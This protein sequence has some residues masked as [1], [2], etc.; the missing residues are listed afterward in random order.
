[1]AGNSLRS[2]GWLGIGI[3]VVLLT[4]FLNPLSALADTNLVVGGQ[5]RISY[6]NGDDVRMRT[7]P[8]YDGTLIKFVPEGTILDVV[9]GPV[10]DNAGNIWY[11]LALDGDTGYIVSDYL[12][13]TDSA[14]P[15]SNNAAGAVVG[16]ALIAG[17][18][19]DGV[20]CRTS[21]S[22]GGAVIT[23]VPEGSIVDLTGAAA[24]GWQPINC[25]GQGG[26]VSTDYVS[27][28]FSNGASFGADSAT[29]SASISGT[30]GD[31][32]RCRASATASAAIITVLSEGSVVS[33]RG[34]AEAGWQPVICAGS[35]G[36]VS[37]DF[38]AYDGGVGADS[39]ATA[40]SAQSTGT[41]TVS[42][43]NGDG[44]RCRTR[45]SLDGSIITVLGEGT[46]VNGRGSQKGDWM[47][48]ACAG[49]N[50]W[51]SA[52]YLSNGG[53][54][55]DGG[56]A[57]SG[58]AT[59]TGTGGGLRCRDDAS[60]NANVLTVLS[61]G[62]SVALR[63]SASGSWQPVVCE[64]MNGYVFSDYLSY[65]G[66][67]T[68]GGGNSGNNN[69]G[70]S[71]GD[72]ATVS[73]TN[74]D[75]VRFRSSASFDGAVIMV[76]GE[77]TAVSVI[78]G[79]TGSWVAIS[80]KGT[81]GFVHSDYL[82]AGGG[83]STDGGTDS[84]SAFDVGDHAKT[85]SDLNLRYDPS[86]SGGIAAVA[87]SGTVVEITGGVSNGYYAVDWD[88]LS[89]YMHG[90][91]L[92][93]TKDGL[94]ERGGS[95]EDGGGT[96]NGN[97]NT[98]GGGSTSTGNAIV[99]YAMQYLGYPYVWATHGPS[100]FDCSGFTYWVIL[101]TL[102]VNISP[103]TSAQINAG[104]SVSRN[105]LQPGDL[106]FFQNTYTWGLSHVGI[107]IGNGKFIHAENESTGVVISDLSSSYYSSRWYGARRIG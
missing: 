100:S 37:A 55:S 31:G 92:A 94:S 34:D 61:D 5:A 69:T 52:Q 91:Y 76:L 95:G 48:V 42:G 47:P 3:V 2:H 9:D 82:S 16:S 15:T 97:G 32:V 14:A 46:T 58:N 39:D 26:F 102:G 59:V 83:G 96:D 23:V 50:G 71:S 57:T 13:L 17:T 41:Y 70:F 49:S 38:V 104:T 54:S 98:D 65:G 89:G 28:D 101:N 36:Y 56:G 21:A 7:D 12:A 40:F 90:D 62:T 107:Y 84:S 1:M 11:L 103:G 67:S 79:S 20:R 87:P 24:S 68:D 105:S 18:N 8:S 80:Y 73:G 19:N 93:F 99:D 106:V 35:N 66:G 4:T 45:A 72:N 77:G 60:Y 53:G 63:G 27:Y 74:G 6:A 29:G 22:A 43:T 44:V 78:N 25:A 85:L 75:G 33:L 81:S 86:T 30:N 51:V 88:G 64:G 10:T